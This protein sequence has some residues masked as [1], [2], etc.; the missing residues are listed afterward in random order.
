MNSNITTEIV[1]VTPEMAKDWLE[2]ATSRQRKMSNVVVRDYAKE[3]KGGYWQLNGESIKFD[4]NGAMIDG[5]HRL[6]A[7]IKSDTPFQTVVMHGMQN[8]AFETI[9][10]GKMRSG[11]D[12]FHILGHS[13]PNVLAGITRLAIAY[14]NLPYG[15]NIAHNSRKTKADNHE[16]R[17]FYEGD[18]ESLD[19]AVHIVRLSEYKSAKKILAPSAF[20]FLFLLFKKIDEENCLKFFHTFAT[21][22]PSLQF[23]NKQLNCPVASAR[24]KLIQLHMDVGKHAQARWIAHARIAVCLT[25]WNMLLEGK[26]VTIFPKAESKSWP[27]IGNDPYRDP[28]NVIEHPKKK[29]KQHTHFDSRQSEMAV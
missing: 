14:K 24:E 13:D 10:T 7:Y 18:K 4:V 2:R 15:D 3:M 19:Y 17:V 16:M 6:K 12:I 22:I 8:D 11:G 27:I 29:I 26:G 5:Q 21:G 20:G 9:D 1:T 23:K 25:A 28:N